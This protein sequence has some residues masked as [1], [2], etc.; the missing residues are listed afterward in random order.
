MTEQ[1]AKE[2]SQYMDEYERR[3]LKIA[4]LQFRLNQ[5]NNRA[6]WIEL[7]KVGRDNKWTDIQMANK[8]LEVIKEINGINDELLKDYY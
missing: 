1:D 5:I 6:Y 3:E 7:L 2:Y 4:N 8:I